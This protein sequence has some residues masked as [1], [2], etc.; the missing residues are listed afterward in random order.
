M[1][2]LESLYDAIGF[3]ALLEHDF[4]PF[5]LKTFLFSTLL[6]LPMTGLHMLFRFIYFRLYHIFKNDRGGKNG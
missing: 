6:A 3:N 2:F 1:E 5:I 4:R